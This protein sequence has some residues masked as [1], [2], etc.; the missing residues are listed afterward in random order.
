MDFMKM[1]INTEIALLI[2]KLIK[3]LKKLN[4]MFPSVFNGSSC[5]QNSFHVSYTNTEI[6][7]V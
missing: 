7:Y 5:D 1:A 6:F 2:E 4:M 3:S